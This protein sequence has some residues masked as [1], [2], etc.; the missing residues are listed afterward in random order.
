MTAQAG[1]I[2]I[3][4]GKK[5]SMTSEPLFY[6]IIHRRDI[7]FVAPSTLCYRGYFG[8]WEIKE[9]KL[10]L[11][12]LKAYIKGYE[13]VGVDY[14]FPGQSEAFASWFTGEIRI[15]TGKL[16]K[17]VHSGYESIFQKELLLFFLEGKFCGSEERLNHRK[18]IDYQEKM[19]KKDNEGLNRLIDELLKGEE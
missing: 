3:Y 7:Q 1:D 12:H 14:L 6:Y 15:P 18:Y 13:K 11:I 16:L 8:T 2:I 17:Y 19:R 9:G 10:Y 4:N 5:H